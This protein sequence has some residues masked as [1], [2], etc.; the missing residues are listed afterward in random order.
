MKSNDQI[1]MVMSH[2]NKPALNRFMYIN[3]YVGQRLSQS[4][5]AEVQIILKCIKDICIQMKI[6]KYAMYMYFFK[7]LLI[8]HTL[9]RGYIPVGTPVQ[10]EFLVRS[11]CTSMKI[12]IQKPHPIAR[13][14]VKKKRSK[15]RKKRKLYCTAVYI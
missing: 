7:G 5:L 6:K 15:N 8:K 10:S 14:N 12:G 4:T 13:L 9:C 1:E 11:I 2:P 3:F